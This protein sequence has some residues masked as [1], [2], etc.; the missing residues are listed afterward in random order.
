MEREHGH[1]LSRREA[2]ALTGGAAALI[3]AGGCAPVGRFIL[4]PGEPLTAAG[5]VS[6]PVV[7]AWNRFGYGPRPGDVESVAA[8]GLESWWR[9]QLEGGDDPA[10]VKQRKSVMAIEL[11]GMME[12]RDWHYRRIAGQ[13]Q[14]LQIMR[15]VHSPFGLQERLAAF[16]SD[17]LNVYNGKGLA[18]YRI[19]TFVRTVIRPNALGNVRDMIRES[20]KASAML[21]YLDQQNSTR[22]HPNE[23]YA[24]ELLELHTLGVDAGYTQRDVME[25][26]RALTGWVEERGF[27]KANGK[28][29]F[30][31]DIHDDGEKTLLGQT[32]PAGGGERDAER[33]LEIV[34][35]HPATARHL[36]GKMVRHFVAEPTPGL[37]GRAEAAFAESQGAVGPV[38]Q[39]I[40]ESGEWREGPGLAKRPYDFLVSGL[41]ALGA[42]STGE[43]GAATALTAMGQTLNDWPMPD[44]YPVEPEAWTGSMLGRWNTAFE[45][46]KNSRWSVADFSGLLARWGGP[47]GEAA[48]RA[49]FHAEPTD[50]LTRVAQA[51]DASG[52]GE[53]RR[54]LAM[55][56]CAPEFQWR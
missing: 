38:M 42:D 30:R 46:T 45:I 37:L 3:A 18:A 21:V 26:A 54:Q 29:V 19:P 49:V 27:L 7:R 44:G 35:R 24:R 48:V 39:T 53:W 10:I 22:M 6:D 51:I 17:H 20:M 31:A 4:G 28:V 50:G 52:E 43:H 2:M 14:A 40:F 33:V 56:I 23:N 16:W 9:S 1:E 36:S 12:M 11:M 32:I 5:S 8:S 15:A 55:A 25:V 34:M 47:G 41:R 13:A